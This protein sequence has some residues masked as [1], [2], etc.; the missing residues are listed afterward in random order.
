MIVASDDHLL[1]LIMRGRRALPHSCE[2]PVVNPLL[3]PARQ[4]PTP[5]ALVLTAAKRSAAVS[6]DLVHRRVEEPFP[7]TALFFRW[8]QSRAG[9]AVQ[10]QR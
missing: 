6:A 2:P 3:G 5:D 7:P 9:T 8:F 10:G 1:R 4:F